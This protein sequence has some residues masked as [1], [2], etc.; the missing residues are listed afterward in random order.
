M[1]D[2]KK[3]PAPPA[4]SNEQLMALIGAAR[5][6]IESLQARNHEAIAVVGMGMRLPGDVESG[7]DYW[8]FLSRGGDGIVDV[9]PERW[10]VEGLVQHSGDRPVDG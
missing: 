8:N 9:P 2:Q 5:K 6:K 7:D 3:K 1:T 10:D 4:M